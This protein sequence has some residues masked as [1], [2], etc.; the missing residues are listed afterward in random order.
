MSIPL[1]VSPELWNWGFFHALFFFF[2]FLFRGG[3]FFGLIFPLRS[4]IGGIVIGRC[5]HAGSRVLGA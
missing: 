2:L 3:P 1:D 4:F 5:V